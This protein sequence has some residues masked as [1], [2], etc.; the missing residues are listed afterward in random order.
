[1]NIDGQVTGDDYT[2]IDASLNT[3]PVPGL[4]WLSGDANLDGIVTGDDYTVID[5]NLGLGAGMPLASSRINPTPVPDP[6]A[7]SVLLLPFALPRRR[8]ATIR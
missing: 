4:E 8:C 5:A 1:M 2:V 7:L 6:A 3:D